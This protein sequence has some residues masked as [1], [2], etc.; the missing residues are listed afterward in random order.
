MLN[1]FCLKYFNLF[2]FFYLEY[3]IFVM[4]NFELAILI[5]ETMT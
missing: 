2:A 3:E 5:G 4:A 1:K